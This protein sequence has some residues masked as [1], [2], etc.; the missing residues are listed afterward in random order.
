MC[1]HWPVYGGIGDRRK[2][3]CEGRMYLMMTAIGRN[4][5]CIQMYDVYI[6]QLCPLSNI[7]IVLQYDATIR[8]F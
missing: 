4:M 6:P 8:Y 5:Q 3:D 2:G 1:K 7:N